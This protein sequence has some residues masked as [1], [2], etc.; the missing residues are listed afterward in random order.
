MRRWLAWNLWF[1]LQEFVKGHPTRAILREMEAA[2]R[3][4][5]SALRELQR[6]KLRDLLEYSYRH[7][8]YVRKRMQE[9]GIEP[10]DIAGPEDLPKLPLLR[11]ADVRNH[12][13]ELRSD[14]AG[15]L[16]S[17]TTGGSTGEPLIFDLSR[18]RTAARVACR[19]RVGRWWGVSIGDPEIA[20]WG[21]P[22]ELSRQDRIRSIR[23]WLLATR[24]LSAFEMNEARMSEYLD[25]IERQGCRQIF[26]YPSAVYLLCRQAQKQGRD[27]RR[28]GIQAVF[29]TGE[30][31]FPYQRELIS[32][33]LNCPVANGYGGR[34]SGFLSHECPQG[35]MHI[36]ADAV[37]VEI[38]DG[39]GR[40]APPGEPGEIVATDLY[41]HEFPFI[42]Y[43]TGD[44]GVASARRCSCGRA[45]PLLERIDGRSND[46]I[47]AP[48]GRIINS[49]ALVYPLREIAGI[50]QYRIC[51]KST[52]RFHVQIVVNE[53]YRKEGEERIRAGWA[54]LLRAPVQ[55]SFEYLP[56][57][58]A[59]RQG[60]FRHIT[61]EVP[62]GRQ[63][64]NPGVTVSGI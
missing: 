22:V 26:G 53:G 56:G 23:D 58:P 25:I 32:D 33:V 17:F 41:S 16:S 63:I 40:P 47:V 52:D 4:A 46:S 62:A 43:A 48:D 2:D 5:E 3:L 59:E 9:A 57:I 18:R 31:L 35:G 8:P 11:K 7:V 54:K 38:V 39:Q 27:L 34:D 19:I 45:L 36:L 55:V 24:L 1:P 37:V 30:V 42:R 60:K 15:K 10:G 28:L 44:I 61:S 14:C 13:M 49:L 29:V 64:E 50:E 21:S 6:N 12:R 20:L 51:Q